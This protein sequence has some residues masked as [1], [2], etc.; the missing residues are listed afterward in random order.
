MRAGR[1]E[2]VTWIKKESL[3]YHLK[4]DLHACAVIAQ[5]ESLSSQAAREWSLQEEMAMEQQMDFIQ[6]TLTGGHKNKMM[7]PTRVLRISEEEKEM[8]ENFPSTNESFDAR[9]DSSAAAAEERKRLEKQANDFDIWHVEDFLPEENT[10]T[11]ELLLEELEQDD[12][13]TELLRNASKLILLISSYGM[14]HMAF[15]NR[16]KCT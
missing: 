15:L 12:I 14:M 5:R 1:P 11:S 10:T 6:L 13:L 16:H 9:L 7:E 3:A 4:S 2:D 8:W